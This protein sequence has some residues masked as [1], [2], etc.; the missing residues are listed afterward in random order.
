MQESSISRHP[1][2][3]VDQVLQEALS[4]EDD[5]RH[6]PTVDQLGPEAALL[7][8]ELRERQVGLGLQATYMLSASRTGSALL[9]TIVT[10]TML[11]TLCWHHLGHGLSSISGPSR[12]VSAPGYSYL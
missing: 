12:T 8:E 2:L 4:N 11:T 6:A 3:C 9:P 5:A 10:V 1:L 7:L